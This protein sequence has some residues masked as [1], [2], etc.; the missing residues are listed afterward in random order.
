[1]E[2]VVGANGIAKET[3]F[4][5]SLLIQYNGS[6]SGTRLTVQQALCK[7]YIL[8]NHR[9]NL[10]G[11]DDILFS[12]LPKENLLS[13][14][15]T[16]IELIPSVLMDEFISNSLIQDK[17]QYIRIV[18]ALLINLSD[19]LISREDEFENVCNEI[20]N[21]LQFIQN[22]F[23]QQFDLDSRLT[24]FYLYQFC[25]CS[26]LKLQYW[27][28]KLNDSP[29]IDALREC[30]AEKFIV[31]ENNITYR[32]ISYLKYILQEIESATSVISEKYVR[33]VFMYNNFN[34]DCFINYEIELIQTELRKFQTNQEAI[35]FLQS[36][37]GR[38]VKL[39]MKS[40]ISFDNQQASTKKQLSDWITEEI[41]QL[42]LKNRKAAD[43]DL[44]IDPE[45]KIQTSLSVAKLAVL[46]RVMVVDKIII[47][48][49]VAPMLRTITKLFTTLQKDEISFGSLETKYHAP[50]KTT[51]NTMK[52]MLQ[53]WVAILS[54]L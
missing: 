8:F 15:Q 43:K 3:G 2:S 9:T 31:P 22:F 20:E 10:P 54:K 34:S 51:L 19:C 5:K 49:S 42:E 41:K 18:Q 44:L 30:L 39:K 38:I 13:S 35:L 45:S 11:T 37:Q 12:E 24:Q 40:G 36:E 17:D 46:I 33:E 26:K 14:L 32:K 7:W 52:E 16:D 1:M 25:K 29:L 53:K 47:N 6:D 50:D 48:K 4:T 23:Y 28:I 21:I 27:Q